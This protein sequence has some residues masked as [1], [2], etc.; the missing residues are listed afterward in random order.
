VGNHRGN[1]RGNQNDNILI[2]IP[3]LRIIKMSDSVLIDYTNY[4]GERSSRTI[5]PQK[6]VFES[7]EYHPEKQWILYALD[8]Q[9]NEVRGFAMKDIHSWS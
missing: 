4:R 7:N 2:E 8:V 9:K 5:I 1:H 3:I 6:I